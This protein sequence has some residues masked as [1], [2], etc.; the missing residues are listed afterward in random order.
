MEVRVLSAAPSA[1]RRAA[2][3]RP[4]VLRDPARGCTTRGIAGALRRLTPLRR[5]RKLP[6]RARHRLSR[7]RRH[8]LWIAAGS[9]AARPGR[10]A[11]PRDPRGDLRLGP[12]RGAR[13]AAAR[14]QFR[15]GPRVRG[16]GR[17]GR[18]RRAARA[19]G[20]SRAGLL[21]HRLWP[22]RSLPTRSGVGLR[23]HHRRRRLQPVRLLD[24]P[25]RRP[26]RG[27]ARALRR[28]QPAAGARGPRRRAGAVPR[29]HPA[30]RPHG[31]RAGRG[32]ARG[33]GRGVRRRSG[34]RVRAALCRAA[35]RCAH[36]GGGPRRGAARPRAPG[37]TTP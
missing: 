11:A 28:R 36:R 4:E 30:D 10:R 31:G 2:P 25:A 7:P 13:D 15:P 33:G 18:A 8:P 9:R 20:R 23:G 22:L 21:H 32:G 3:P 14:A 27:G 35:R 6:T 24:R 12:P 16:G 37:A 26:G 19:Q 5:R 29:R 1:S 17:G 34:R